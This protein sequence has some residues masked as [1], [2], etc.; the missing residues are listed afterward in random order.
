MKAKRKVLIG[1]FLF[2][3]GIVSFILFVPDDG[4]FQICMENDILS[5]ALGI[6]SF[7][8][9]AI[10][11]TV[12]VA[13]NEKKIYQNKDPYKF[14]CVIRIIISVFL[15]AFCI[16]MFSISLWKEYATVSV[17]TFVLGIIFILLVIFHSKRIDTFRKIESK[18]SNLDYKVNSLFEQISVGHYTNTLLPKLESLFPDYDIKTDFNLKEER[19]SIVLKYLHVRLKF[20]FSIEKVYVKMDLPLIIYETLEDAETGVYIEELR[21]DY[22]VLLEFDDDLGLSF[23]NNLDENLENIVDI[24]KNKFDSALSLKEKC[25]AMERN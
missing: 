19:V 4:L 21:R 6:I 17:V 16:V 7:L 8:A 22:I 25:E 10:A 3:V 18:Y 5:I 15:L 20:V 9:F 1:M 14:D 12:L 13:N 11:G 24:M 2:L 23:D